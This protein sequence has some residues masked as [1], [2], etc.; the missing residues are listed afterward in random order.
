M[1]LPRGDAQRLRQRRQL[2]AKFPAQADIG[3]AQLAD[4]GGIDIQV[5][6]L[7]L[8]REGV[9]LAG[10]PV[11]EARAGDDQQIAFLHRVI[12]G[13]IAVH[14][15]HAQVEW[16]IRI[17]RAQSFQRVHRR[18]AGRAHQ[19]AQRGL[20]IGHVDAAAD[21]Q[22]RTLR[23]GD[24]R[25]RAA[26]AHR[27]HRGAACELFQRGARAAAEAMATSFGRSISTGP[28]RP[29]RAMANASRTVA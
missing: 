26:S 13:R 20:G 15:E 3:L 17:D 21:V 6:D 4:L 9:Q 24:Q 19:R 14:A 16:R 23:L 12:G 2:F 18:Q 10:G 28:G 8:R 11:I 25:A 1:L 7:C 29:E 27:V 22:Q 5:Q